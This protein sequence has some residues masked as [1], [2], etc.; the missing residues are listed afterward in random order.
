MT[1]T[2]CRPSAARR[3]FWCV[4]YPRSLDLAVQHDWASFTCQECQEFAPVEY[5][6]DELLADYAAC[7]GLILAIFHPEAVKYYKH[8][9][10][11]DVAEDVF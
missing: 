5:D 9:R 11:S 6:R 4:H 8:S 2:P 3:K 1:P 10:L 7:R